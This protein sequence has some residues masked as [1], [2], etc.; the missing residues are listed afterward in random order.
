MGTTSIG[1]M[2]QSIADKDNSAQGKEAFGIKQLFFEPFVGGGLIT[3]LSPILISKMGLVY[4]TSV[5]FAL[6]LT[7]FLIGFYYCKRV[8]HKETANTIER[9]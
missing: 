7:F 9:D 8:R 3:A 6:M 2:L 1:L 4:F 5:S